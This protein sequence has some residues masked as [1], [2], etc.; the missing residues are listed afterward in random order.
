MS[1]NNELKVEQKRRRFQLLQVKR[2]NGN[3]ENKVLDYLTIT[4]KT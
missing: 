2:A 3:F 4:V 1:T